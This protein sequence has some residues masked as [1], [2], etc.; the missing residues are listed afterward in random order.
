MCIADKPRRMNSSGEYGCNQGP[1][2]ESQDSCLETI[3]P[4]LRQILTKQAYLASSLELSP[5]RTRQSRLQISISFLSLAL[6]VR[7]GLHWP[8]RWPWTAYIR[9]HLKAEA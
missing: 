2:A 1:N 4:T 8:S 6:G 3:L 7:P 5:C 9:T